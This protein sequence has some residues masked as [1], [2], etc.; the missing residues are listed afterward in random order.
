MR[1]CRG[2]RHECT[3][4]YVGHRD[5]KREKSAEVRQWLG[6]FLTVSGF[7]STLSNE[8]PLP[9]GSKPSVAVL[10][11]AP[12]MDGKPRKVFRATARAIDGGTENIRRC[13]K[14]S[15]TALPCKDGALLPIAAEK[16]GALL[17]I[18]ACPPDPPF[19][20]T[21]TTRF[22]RHDNFSLFP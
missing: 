15:I 10:R 22:A 1:P 5:D 19:S 18:C 17:P 9:D 20:S 11:A 7:L 12:T 3:A 14:I 6:S 8:R 21:Q 16:G 4:R 13:P 2:Q